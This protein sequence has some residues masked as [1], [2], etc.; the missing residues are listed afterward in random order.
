MRKKLLYLLLVSVLFFFSCSSEELP[1]VADGAASVEMPVVIKAGTAKAISTRESNFEHPGTCEVNELLLLVYSGEVNKLEEL[2][3]E[4]SLTLSCVKENDEWVARG[5]I[6]GKAGRYYAVFALGYNKEKEAELFSVADVNGN[7]LVAKTTIYDDTRIVLNPVPVVGTLNRYDTP[8]FFAGNVR[9]RDGFSETF[10]ADGDVQLTG[11]LYRAVGKGSLTVT[12][13]PSN[14]RKITWMTEKI[15][16]NNKLYRRLTEEGKWGD[17]PMGVPQ[18]DE[19]RKAIS[20]VA[21]V[22]RGTLDADATTWTASL[23]SFFIP[24]EKSQFY[25]DAT[26]N[27]GNSVRYMVKSPD[28]WVYTVW[29]GIIAYI[30]KSNSFS[31]YPNYWLTLN[32]TFDKLKDGANI[33]MDFTPM[34]EYDAGYMP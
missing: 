22:E 19:Q 27:D 12:G 34:E 15:A 9:T 5:S 18:A 33:R 26:D 24:L 13:V 7:P 1:S 16:D 30:V 29:I 14:I 6:K 20:E 2:I 23:E 11:W 10:M 25:L 17:Y 8:E 28:H 4:S 3:Y 32:G 31:I 21:S